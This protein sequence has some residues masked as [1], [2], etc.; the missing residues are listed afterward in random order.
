MDQAAK[1]AIAQ[2]G[3]GYWD[4]SRYPY[5]GDFRRL[6]EDTQ[7]EIIGEP[8]RIKGNMEVRV[9]FNDGRNGMIR[10]SALTEL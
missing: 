8:I 10:V 5:G 4:V 6:T 7:V 2:S 1:M 9:R 3:Y